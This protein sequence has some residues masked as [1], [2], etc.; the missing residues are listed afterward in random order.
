MD[1]ARILED[2]NGVLR[3]IQRLGNAP[4]TTSTFLQLKEELEWS[5]ANP[6]HPGRGVLVQLMLRQPAT[7]GILKSNLRHG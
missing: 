3:N 6:V 2:V 4:R 5:L 1:Y 7:S